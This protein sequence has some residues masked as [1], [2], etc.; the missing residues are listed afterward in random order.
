MADVEI[1]AEIEKRLAEINVSE[2]VEEALRTVEEAN[3]GEAVREAL[4]EARER[5]EEAKEANRKP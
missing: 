2:I 1:Q 5:T 3:I 4:E